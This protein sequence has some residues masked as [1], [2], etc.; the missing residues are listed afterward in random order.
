MKSNKQI[1]SDFLL[2]L[3]NNLSKEKTLIMNFTNP[4]ILKLSILNSKEIKLENDLTDLKNE[5]FELIIGD[6]PFGLQI[7]ESSST[8]KLNVNKNWN[9]ALLALRNL[10]NHGKAYFLIEPSII[11]SQ[12]GKRFLQDLSKEY[13]FLNSVF[14]LPEK[15]L[16]PESKFQPIIIG[17]ERSENKD[18]FIGE[19]TPDFNTLIENFLDL[20]SSKDLST[21]IITEKSKF[22]SISQFKIEN[23]INILKIQYNDYSTYSLKEI[24]TIN[25]TKTSFKDKQNAIY[26]PKIGTSKVVSMIENTTLKHQNYFQVVLNE[27]LVNADY[28]AIFY[29]SELGKLILKSIT[30][31]NFIPNINKSD[32]ELS[33]VAIPKLEE[34]NLIV[35]TSKKLS[36]LQETIS[37]LKSELSLNPK[38]ANVILDKF[39]SIYSPFKQLSNE[40]L[41]YSL[42]RKDENKY[43]EFKETFSKSMNPKDRKSVV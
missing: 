12:Q 10:S 32:V 20:K 4:N 23:Q 19:I 26:I 13:Y 8:S 38:N 30:T 36:E 28:L 31:G 22:N 11:F 6:L 42:I 3:T 2:Q 35:I 25:L 24:A 33:S 39:E 7:V 1:T 41:I 14:E 16:Y 29:Q 27:N 17:F 5:Q 15:F 9:Y 43:I 40:D 37:Q 18:L 34:Q 21:G